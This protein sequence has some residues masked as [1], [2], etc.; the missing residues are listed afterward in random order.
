[1]ERDNEKPFN[2]NNNYKLEIKTG[3]GSDLWMKN[4]KDYLLGALGILLKKS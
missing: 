2:T 3:D 4:Y 1:M